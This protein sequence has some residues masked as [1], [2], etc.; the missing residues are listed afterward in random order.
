MELREFFANYRSA[1]P[2]WQVKHDVTLAR[3]N[4]PVKQSICFQALK[5]GAYRP[6]CSIEILCAPPSTRILGNWLDI[7]HQQIDRREHAEKWPRVVTAMEK[8]FQPAIRSQLNVIDVLRLGE[9]EIKVKQIDNIN[10]SSGLA[11]LNAY[12]DNTA[13]ASFWC[14]RIEEQ[15]K[16]RG[17]EPA[18]WEILHAH[19]ALQLR[20]A[21]QNGMHRTYLSENTRIA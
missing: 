1:F 21:I 11:A 10:N 20:H 12:V 16:T 6:S 17:R 3:A 2:D 8:Q 13:R 7:K 5:S 18:D 15:L 4:G 19:F 9:E 14:D